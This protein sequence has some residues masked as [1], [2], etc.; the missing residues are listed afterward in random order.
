[1]AAEA[2]WTFMVFMAG[3]NNLSDA[4]DEDLAE[5]RKVGS[6]D[7]VNVVVE[8]DN[9]G[10]SGTVRYLVKR[11]GVAES[12]VELGETDSGA[13]EVLTDFIKW[14]VNEYPAQRYALILWNHGGGWEPS[15][16]NKIAR[17]L[18]ARNYNVREASSLSASPIKK[19]FF[20]TSIETILNEDS[21]YAR[22]I[23]VDDGSGH[24]LDT[25]EL[26]NV[27]AKIKELI[28]KPLDLLGMDAC[29]MSNLEVA[30]QAEPYV[31]YIVASEE[32]EP[33]E[34]WPYEA[35]VNIMANNPNISAK[36]LAAE[37]VKAYTKSYQDWGQ[38][39]V[40]Q[41]AF[42][43]SKVKNASKAI[44]SLGKALLD[45]MPDAATHIWKAQKKSKSFFNNT[46]W[47]VSHFSKEIANISQYEEVKMALYQIQ[48]AFKVGLDNFVIAE[49]HLGS[50]FDQCCGSSIYLIPPPNSISKY[51]ADLDFA[52]EIKNWPLMLNEYH[53]AD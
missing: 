43:L 20:K 27:F 46:L 53:K 40:T 13:P 21:Q 7:N 2:K 33:N 14:S 35:V 49:S 15:D 52:K 25:I 24:S 36:D 5:M 18:R 29:L 6:T 26:G 30:Y 23:C 28:G 3:D 31:R 19:T 16:L 12:K 22:A 10:D 41:S 32:S 42:D 51:Y 39:N 8:F 47:D 11:D 44:D 9:A 37:I 50:S 34:G 48:E 1:M 38:T 4:G 17:K 45:N